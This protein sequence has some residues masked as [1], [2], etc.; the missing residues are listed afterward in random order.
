MMQASSTVF[1][2]QSDVCNIKYVQTAGKMQAH[3]VFLFFA[4]CNSSLFLL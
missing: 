3:S 2:V 1:Y 4:C